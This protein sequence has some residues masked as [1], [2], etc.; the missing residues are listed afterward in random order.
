MQSGGACQQS[1]Q[2]KVVQE[3]KGIHERLSMY[4][5]EFTE[6]MSPI[7]GSGCGLTETEKIPPE[8]VWP[9][10]FD[11][12]RTQYMAINERIGDIFQLLHQVRL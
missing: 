11:D 8:E 6:I 10:L 9:A 4:Q 3:L 7:L 5:N 2:S 12:I 1:L